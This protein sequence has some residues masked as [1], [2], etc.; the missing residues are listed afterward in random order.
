MIRV[1]KVGGSLFDLADLPQRLREWL[2]RQPS[3]HSVFIAGGGALVEALRRQASVQPVDEATA[4]WRCIELMSETAHALQ[5]RVRVI[6]LVDDIEALQRRLADDGATIFDSGGWLRKL[7]PRLPGI[8]LPCTW[9]TSSDS[10]AG[11]VAVTLGAHEL[12]LLKSTLPPADWAA[13]SRQ[14][15]AAGYVDAMFP[16]LA[17]ELPPTRF[18]DLR[19]NSFPESP[20]VNLGDFAAANSIE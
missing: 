7:E 18:V 16:R 10:I 6:P 11:R 19:G 12:V 3:A 13:D 20:T 8:Q 14:L 1:V 15:V 9:E 5:R 17:P 2:S 4:H